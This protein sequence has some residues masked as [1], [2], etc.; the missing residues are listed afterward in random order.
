MTN[1]LAALLAK[2]KAESA[3]KAAGVPME[4]SLPADQQESAVPP[5][6][7]PVMEVKAEESKAPS[8]ADKPASAL[9][10]ML[11]T[12]KPPPKT[13]NVLDAQRAM[14]LAK[15]ELT[16]ESLAAS[17]G[18]LADPNSGERFKF[19]LD[20]LDAKLTEIH[21]RMDNFNIDSIRSIVSRIMID[22]KEHPDYEGLYLGDRDVHN[23]MAFMYSVR[24]QAV[25][26]NVKKVVKAE[27]KSKK[28]EKKSALA[29]SLD[30]ISMEGFKL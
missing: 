9:A 19:T 6:P 10:K 26:S 7:A 22:L 29:L 14:E 1:A 27:T 12:P 17:D 30:N 4:S 21:G 24:E 3:A 8:E 15:P 23:I 25:E 5:K 18:N 20:L 28:N 13:S 16:L 11:S 2:K